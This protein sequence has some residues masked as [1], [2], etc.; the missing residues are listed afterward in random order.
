M[1]RWHSRARRP[2]STPG[3]P[4]AD[5]MDSELIM[6][7]DIRRRPRAGAHSSSGLSVDTH[8]HKHDL[9]QLLYAFEGAIEVEGVAGRYRVPSQF[10]AWIPADAPHR[11]SIHHTRS[12]SIFLSRDMLS[13]AP[14]Q[15]VVQVPS[16][17]REMIIHAMRWPI[18][19]PLDALGASYFECFAK[20]C[21]EWLAEEVELILP[22]SNDAQV[23][24]I[25]AYTERNIARV[26]LAELCAAVGMSERTLRRRFVSAVGLSWEEFRKRLRMCLAI[27]LLDETNES[28]GFIAAELGYDNQAAFAKAFRAT[29]G[30]APHAYRKARRLS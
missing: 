18:E 30:L 1:A 14:T 26:T 11:T 17:M 4:N 23:R 2:Y 22:S 29:T 25:I 7:G 13:P 16:L 5:P 10:A 12:G 27:K 6:M 19:Q 21:I 20:L 28:V 9:H 15:R 8:W 3:R 24:A